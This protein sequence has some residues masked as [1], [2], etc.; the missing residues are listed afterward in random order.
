MA[1][2]LCVQVLARVFRYP[3]CGISFFPPKVEHL[4]SVCCHLC[5]HTVGVRDVG[6][7]ELATTSFVKMRLDAVT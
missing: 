6:S 1:L 2:R 4:P 3:V 7:V 5:A